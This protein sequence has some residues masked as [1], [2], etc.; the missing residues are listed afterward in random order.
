LAVT[1]A[2]DKE[3]IQSRIVEHIRWAPARESE[4]LRRANSLARFHD[5]P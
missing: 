5:S 1:N 2:G 3:R 4:A